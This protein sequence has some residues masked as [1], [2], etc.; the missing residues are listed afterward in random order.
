M[1]VT[2]S[3]Q[4][5][6]GEDQRLVDLVGSALVDPNLHTDQRM[7]LSHEIGELLRSAH[8]QAHGPAGREAHEQTLAANGHHMSKVLE[9]V[10]V[11]P[12]VRT[13]VRMR[14]MRDVERILSAARN[15]N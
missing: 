13:D 2:S 5:L 10:L 3:T 6:G 14:L 15:T 1:T 12:D 11:D 8:E 7:R 4:P 9:A